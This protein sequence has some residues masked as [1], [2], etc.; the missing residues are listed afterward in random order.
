ML[1][2]VIATKNSEVPLAHC[3]S[4]LVSGAAEGVV[5]D[6]VVV[7]AGSTDG[8]AQV[9]DAA[10][11]IFLTRQAG[12]GDRM[13]TGADAAKRGSWLLFL[14]PEAVLDAGWHQEVGA[15][16]DRLERVGRAERTV[17]VFSYAVDDFGFG[18]RARESVVKLRARVFGLP[19]EDQGLL[20]SR[21]NYERLGGHRD[22]GSHEDIDLVCR[23][24]GKHIIHLRSRAVV[25]PENLSRS[26][27]LLK[28]IRKTAFV[29]L[30][31]LRVPTK[32]IDRLGI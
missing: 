12:R 9:A 17:G 6:V 31:L 22:L 24:G 1:S 5:R 14:K 26:L 4:A 11:C 29:T 25:S 2:V 10:G 21:R 27:S 30:C 13:K 20:I 3:L 15:F 23:I 16:I 19:Y 28:I 18:A 8:T 7:D 32:M